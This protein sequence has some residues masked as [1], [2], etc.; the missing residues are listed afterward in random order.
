MLA[1]Y[2]R[3]FNERNTSE[4]SGYASELLRHFLS[5]EPV[6]GIEA[7]LALV[8]RFLPEVT[9]AEA[10]ALAR[11][12]LPDDNRVVLASAPAEGRRDRGDRRQPAR[13]AARRRDGHGDAVE[14]RDRR[15]RC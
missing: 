7:E 1:T 3:A 4:S 15:T 2:E 5:G 12:L 14:R 13:G 10:A 8:R 6:P 11:E 9:A